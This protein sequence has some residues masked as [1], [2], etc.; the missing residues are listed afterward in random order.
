MF[1]LTFAEI[2]YALRAAA[3]PDLATILDP[4]DILVARNVGPRW[5]PIFPL[6][7]GLVLDSGSVGQHAAV[8]AREY[9]MTAVIGTGDATKRI[10]DKSWMLVDGARG[11]VQIKKN[12]SLPL[13]KQA[14]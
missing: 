6:L 14:E 9:G 3:P 11:I 10:P 5:T 2:L 12:S 7:G 4:G 13:S 1:W 8:T